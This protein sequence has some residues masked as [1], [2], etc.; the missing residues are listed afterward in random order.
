MPTAL[1]VH[2]DAAN[3]LTA[4]WCA[5]A[6]PGDFVL[7]GCGAWPLLALLAAT[8]EEPGRSELAAATGLP[9][10]DAHA[11]ALELLHTLA[12]A[13][14]VSAALGIWVR[15][16]L[17]L[18]REWST[19]L[20]AGTVQ[21]ITD[22]AALDTWADRH[23]GGLI[24]K[25]P[26]PVD[27]MTVMVLATALAARTTWLDPF[28]EDTMSITD[29]P[30]R[31]HAGPALTRSSSRP[32]DATILDATDPVTRVIVCGTGDLDVHLLLG[33]GTPGAVLTAGLEALAGTVPVRGHLPAG[34]RSPGLNVKA[35]KD[36]GQGDRLEMSLPPFEIR[37]LHDLIEQ[38][39]LFGLT[40]VTDSARGHFPGMS[41]HPLYVDQAA[42]DVFAR[43]T[44]DGFDAAA[45]TAMTMNLASARFLH[46]ERTALHTTVTFDRPFGFLAVH[47]P[48]SLAVVAGWVAHPGR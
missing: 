31:G 4:R 19:S 41:E 36:R 3:R 48:T 22:Q 12:Q 8:A 11:G 37:C 7:S 6:G 43:F 47:R 33:R 1:S 14:S 26:L 2:I 5:T 29:G 38:S 34:T 30:W 10:A 18:R 20:P 16:G 32:Q 46:K 23:T 24:E 42:Q 44:K 45:V 17:P 13:E 25:F 28:H 39:A 9:A 27:S 35:V 21:A 40:T 15:Q